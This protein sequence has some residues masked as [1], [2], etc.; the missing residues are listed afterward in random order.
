MNDLVCGGRNI[1]MVTKWGVTVYQFT[2]ILTE[3][4][5]VYVW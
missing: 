5:S 2:N 4:S 3:S 1:E